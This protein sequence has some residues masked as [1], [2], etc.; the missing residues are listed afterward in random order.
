MKLEP[1][2]RPGKV[3]SDLQAE[4]KQGESVAVKTEEEGPEEMN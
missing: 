2:A 1:G 4:R 3:A